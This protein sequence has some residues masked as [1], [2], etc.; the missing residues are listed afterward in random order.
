MSQPSQ[1][2]AQSSQPRTRLNPVVFFGSAVV[3]VAF[4]VWAILSPEGASGAIGVV[5]G[6]ISEWFG[7]FYILL[8]TIIL[9]FV[10]FLALSR[11]GKVN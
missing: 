1:S 8:A 5:V 10:I 7:W 9:A 11:Y 3:I 4:A 2:E 6:W